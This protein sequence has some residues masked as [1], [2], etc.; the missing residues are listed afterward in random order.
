MHPDTF[1]YESHMDWAERVPD[2]VRREPKRPNGAA[3][4]ATIVV[5]VI[6]AV[7]ASWLVLAV[8]GVTFR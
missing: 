8:A 7:A 5:L 2:P 1:D 4:A 3:V 6:G